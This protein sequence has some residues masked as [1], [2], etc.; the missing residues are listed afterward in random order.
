MRLS[1]AKPESHLPPPAPESAACHG[2]PSRRI[3]EKPEAS[4]RSKTRRRGR[5]RWYRPRISAGESPPNLNI[6][7]PKF[8]FL[9][10]CGRVKSGLKPA[11]KNRAAHGGEDCAARRVKTKADALGI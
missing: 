6:Q 4:E 1:E 10:A 9:T 3:A 11:V 5:E 2:A 7:N 8:N